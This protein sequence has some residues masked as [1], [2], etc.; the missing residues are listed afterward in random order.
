MGEAMKTLKEMP[1]QERPRERLMQRGAQSLSDQELIAIVLGRGTRQ[2][3]VLWLA[4]RVV[5]NIDE[6]GL[7]LTVDDLMSIKGIGTAK[8]T[9][10]TAAF[11][12]VRRRI[13]PTGL[14][15]SRPSDA[16]P[17]IQHYGDRTQEH[18]LCIS[19]NGA[20]EV[21]QVRVITIG[22]VNQSHVHPREVFSA[23]IVERASAIIM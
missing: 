12:F 22:L 9:L 13:K 5:Q 6:R 7:H 17:L 2:H 18:F 1:A 10:I 14:K 8:A 19:L 16:L 20:N 15:I 3:D 4:R 21:I 11:E 23:A